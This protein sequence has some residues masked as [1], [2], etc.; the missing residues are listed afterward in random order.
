[1]DDDKLVM[2]DANGAIRMYDPEKFDQLVK[3]IEVEKRFTTRMDEFKNI[4]NQ[5]MSIV[6]Q[7]G[8]AIEEEKLK[9]IGSRNIVESEAEERFRTV[10]EA[11]VR[12]R[13]K[14]AEL[15]RYIAEYDSLKKVEQEQEMYIKH[16]SHASRE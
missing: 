15:D 6:E 16:L 3:T 10:Q 5:T 11:Q 14:Q 13:E 4:V 2:F 8:K 7:L 9:A 12:L 1:M